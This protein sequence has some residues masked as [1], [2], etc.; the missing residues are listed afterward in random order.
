M[1]VQ[2]EEVKVGRER[3][4]KMLV[5]AGRSVEVSGWRRGVSWERG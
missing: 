3:V 2:E 5:M 4:R 1:K